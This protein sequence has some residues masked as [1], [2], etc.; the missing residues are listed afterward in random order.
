MAMRR[1]RAGTCSVVL[2]AAA[3]LAGSRQPPPRPRP[4]RPAALPSGGA[5][6]TGVAAKWAGRTTHPPPP[7]CSSRNG[8]GNRVRRL[9]RTSGGRTILRRQQGFRT[10]SVSPQRC[11]LDRPGGAEQE[12]GRPCTAHGQPA[13]SRVASW[14]LLLRSR[15]LISDQEFP[16]RCGRENG[17]ETSEMLAIRNAPETA[18]EPEPMVFPVFSRPSGKTAPQRAETGSP[19]TA[20]TTSQSAL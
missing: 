2:A 20:S 8:N 11:P 16:V 9:Q 10:G 18:N 17:A 7:P 5:C 15:S 19:Q 3:L 12:F 13:P 6:A 4:Q 1:V 14:P